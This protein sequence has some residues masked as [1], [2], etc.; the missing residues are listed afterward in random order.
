MKFPFLKTAFSFLALSAFVYAAQVNVYSHRHYDSDRLLFERFTEQT[1]IEVNVVTAKAGELI[2]RLER[3]GRLSPADVLITVDIGNL[4]EAKDKELL[5]PI[6]SE[7]IAEN[8]PAHLRD[9]E[10][11]W[12]GLTKRARII[13]YNKETVDPAELSTYEA[14]AQ[15]AFEGRILV[16]SSGNIYNQSLLASLIAHHG[17][18][19][20]QEWAEGI[21]ANMARTPRGNDRDQ[22]RAV[23]AGEADLAIANT[24]YMGLLENA[25]NEADRTVAKS[26]GIFFP[27]QEGRGAHINIS[28]AAVTAS[29][30]NK[31]AATKLIEFLTS[32]EAQRIFARENYEYPA[33]PAVA[34][35]E[36][37]AAW[38]QFKE[39]TI[40]LT[41]V[42]QQV[43]KAIGVFDRAGWR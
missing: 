28:G 22:I 34:V 3:E 23:A 36:T 32:E 10:N 18:E 15:P 41:K 42:G 26:V 19:A 14:L 35:S 25:P 39:D 27:N 12:H 6:E 31:E 2:Q 13:V 38:G 4:Q 20:A 17:E 29:S 30:Q 33:N 5:Q 8:I 43:H 11:Y 24:Y 16:R 9:G 1:G 7:V 21:V 40:S 37:V